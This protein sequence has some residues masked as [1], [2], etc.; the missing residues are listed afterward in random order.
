MK[1]VEK[2]KVHYDPST[3]QVK[4]FYPD[5]LSTLQCPSPFIVI[6]ALEWRAAL[7]SQGEKVVSDDNKVVVKVLTTSEKIA[8]LKRNKLKELNTFYNGENCWTFSLVSKTKSASLTKSQSWF[9]SHLAYVYG[10]IML[11]SDSGQIV[12]IAVSSDSITKLGN[13]IAI[14]KGLEVKA[15]YM[16]ILNNINNATTIAELNKIVPTNNMLTMVERD[17]DMDTFL[18]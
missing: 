18:G 9:A 10:E 14:K 3:K 11:F 8:E 4:G 5:G 12:T 15:A 1:E 16:T 6:S 13:L 2:V 7:D 17:I